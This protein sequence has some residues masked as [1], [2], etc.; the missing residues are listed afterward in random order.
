MKIL[1]NLTLLFLSLLINVAFADD[2]SV[3]LSNYSSQT[4]Q[5]SC[6]LSSAPMTVNPLTDSNICPNAD[7]NVL[8]KNIGV[9]PI[10]ILCKVPFGFKTENLLPD[11]SS[12]CYGND[13]SYIMV[14]NVQTTIVSL[15][16][17]RNVLVKCSDDSEPVSLNTQGYGFTCNNVS[18]TV[19]LI[20]KSNSPLYVACLFGNK[21]NNIIFT[22]PINSTISCGVNNT[23]Q[24]IFERLNDIDSIYSIINQYF[25]L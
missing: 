11:N 17:N 2:N 19:S 25:K 21:L 12:T 1:L 14:Q 13:S 6:N 3:Y 15:V 24:V 23:Y 9:K 8:V 10:S 18:D 5:F 7:G 20:N 4:V 16:H 22:L